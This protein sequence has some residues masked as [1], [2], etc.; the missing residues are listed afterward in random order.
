MSDEPLI[1]SKP[2]WASKGVIGSVVVILVSAISLAGMFIPSLR[3]LQIN[4][5]GLVEVISAAIT[6]IFGALALWGRIKANSP[7]HFRSR[8]TQPGGEFNPD[9]E[10]R[11]AEPANQPP[12]ANRPHKGGFGKGGYVRLPALVAGV[13]WIG[14]FLA[15]ILAFHFATEARAA[16]ARPVF[17]VERYADPLETPDL[18]SWIRYCELTDNRPFFTR[19]IASVRPKLSWSL[20]TNATNG[21]VE[22]HITRIEVQGGAEF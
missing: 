2:A 6:L 3:D 16:E 12:R 15:L 4:T 7:V 14:A 5:D 22:A 8:K 17:R 10:V 19:L 1:V 18:G 11:R 21:M 9:A 20:G 13:I